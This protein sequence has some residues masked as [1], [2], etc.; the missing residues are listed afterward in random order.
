MLDMLTPDDGALLGV[1]VFGFFSFYLIFCLMIK[2]I[3]FI[4]NFFN[5]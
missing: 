3:D 5:L 4:K 1:V 2:V